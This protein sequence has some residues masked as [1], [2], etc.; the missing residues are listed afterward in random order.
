MTIKA[1]A[2]KGIRLVKKYSPEILLVTGIGTGIA[3]GYYAYK[4]SPKIH[5][6]LDNVEERQANDIEVTKKEIIT[7]VGKEMAIPLVLT[8]TSVTSFIA[9]YKIQYSR[10]AGLS[11][12]LSAT[13]TEYERFQKRTKEVAGEKKYEEIRKPFEERV[14]ET[15]EGGEVK[16]TYTIDSIFDGIWWK[17]SSFYVSDDFEYN[18]QYVNSL[19]SELELSSFNKNGLVLNEVLEKLGF[20]KSREGALLGWIDQDF[21]FDTEVIHVD[22]YG[23]GEKKPEIYIKWTHKPTY[24][25][26]KVNYDSPYYFS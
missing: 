22:E 10:I 15:E 9:S 11:A 17:G 25:Y 6:Y 21:T 3:A 19:K 20:D 16:K 12:A 7:T 5:E 4:K 14:E 2:T 24:I 8:V 23:T 13:A 1:L 26:S 18:M